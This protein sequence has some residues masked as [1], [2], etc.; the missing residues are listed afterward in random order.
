MIKFIIKRLVIY[1]IIVVPSIIAIQMVIQSI[2]QRNMSGLLIA[3]FYLVL[4]TPIS[5]DLLNKK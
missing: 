4:S 1:F 3:V 2:H 5:F